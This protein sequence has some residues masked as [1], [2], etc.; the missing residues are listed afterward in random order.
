LTAE[1]YYKELAIQA[2]VNL[3]ANA[4]SRSEFVTYSEGKT[5]KKDNYYLFNVEPNQNKSASKFWRDVI[6]KLVYDNECLVIQHR[7][8]FY[9]AENYTVQPYAF[10]ENIYKDVVVENLKMKKIFYEPEVFHF[11]L[12]NE[13]IKTLIDGLY[14]SYSKLIAASQSQYRKNNARRGTLEI[15]T[16]Y[17]ETEQA[18]AKLKKLLSGNF[19]KYF[20]AENGA[21]LPLTNGMKYKESES[22]IGSKGG[23]QGKDIRAFVDDIFDFV[24][25]AF[26]VPP[27]LIKGSIADT[28]KVVNNL[29]TFCISPLT[30][31]LEDEI[32]RKLYKKAAYLKRTY[33]KIDPTRIRNIDITDLASSLDILVRV[34]GFTIDDV[35]KRLGME[36]LETDYSQARWMTKNYERIDKE[37]EVNDAGATT[38]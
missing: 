34:G 28:E 3:I 14:T 1:L 17:P 16:S 21:V 37:K 26:Q 30:E 23:S 35:L 25:I 2:C 27:Q 11:E 8:M 12:H 20:N 29:L 36:P 24:A 19:E 22:N 7:D 10:K 38:K 6:S 33:L 9:V 5:I 31:L 13:K 15:P 4:V 18:Q 32:N